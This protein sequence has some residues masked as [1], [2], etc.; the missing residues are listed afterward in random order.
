MLTEICEIWQHLVSWA[1]LLFS[2]PFS[3]DTCWSRTSRRKPSP[4]VMITAWLQVTLPRFVH[5]L[6][7]EGISE[8]IFSTEFPCPLTCYVSRKSGNK[9]EIVEAWEVLLYTSD[10]VRSCDQNGKPNYKNLTLFHLFPLGK[11]LRMQHVEIVVCSCVFPQW[12][13]T[14]LTMIWG[15]LAKKRPVKCYQSPSAKCRQRNVS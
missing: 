6:D 10:N 13:W 2:T 4:S 12:K 3:L 8:L 5:V 15:N 7:T 11:A 1:L 9:K 14:S